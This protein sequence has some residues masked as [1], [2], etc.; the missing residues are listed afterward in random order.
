MVRSTEG[1]K[2]DKKRQIRLNIAKNA[3]ASEDEN[4][5]FSNSLLSAHEPVENTDLE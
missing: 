4:T 1:V 5:R 3:L 2:R